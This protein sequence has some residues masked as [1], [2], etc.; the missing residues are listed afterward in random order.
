[1]FHTPR[2]L[3]GERARRLPGLD[4]LRALAIILVLAYHLFPG[5]APGGFLGVDVF[6]VVSGYLITTLL[7]NEHRR[8][9]RIALRRF[10]MRRARR[11]LPALLL[12][13]TV[14]AGLAALIGG[15]VLVGIGWQLAGALTFS[16]NWFS[17]ATGADYL[18]QT[19][20][21]L[22]RHLWSLAVEEQF[23]LLWPVVL[24]ALFAI[25]RPSIRFALV[26]ALAV[27]SAVGMA[28][29]AG[30]PALGTEAA[31][32]AYFSTLTHGFGL[33]AGA[34]LALL[35]AQRTR[36]TDVT[37][38]ARALTDSVGAVAML[39][40]V[41]LSL[42]L[43]IDD[44]TTY[45][46]GLVLAVAL[47]LM[48]ISA[49]DRDGSRLAGVLDA[50]LPR[51]IG[52]RSY[53]LYLWHWP[54]IVLLGARLPDLDRGSLGQTWLL[55]VVALAGSLLLAAASYRLVESPF[56]RASRATSPLRLRAVAAVGAL[57]LLAAASSAVAQAPPR[58]EAA[59]LIA[60]GQL[61]VA[62]SQRRAE[63]PPTRA[64]EPEG[65]PTGLLPT[66]DDITAIGDSVMLAAA[67]QLQ[68][69]FPGMAIDA[70][71]SRQM[72]EAPSIVRALVEAD[73]LRSTV[74]LGLGTNGPIDP[75]TLHEVRALLGPERTLVLVS[76]QAPRGWTEGVNAHLSDF[77]RAYRLVELSDW[78]AAIRPRLSLL[79][80]DQVHP[81]P[82][83]GAVYTE[84]LTA[85]L[86]RI[87]DL[88]PLVDYEANPELL[89][90]R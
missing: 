73:Q 89:R 84:T 11:L 3:E 35:R 83:G 74:V 10:W 79:A 32:A 65:E 6:L 87:A 52:E 75:E 18:T 47:T 66:G 2:P 37:A 61:A 28:L 59:E 5:L 38:R 17:I 62:E 58:S 34:A 29:A 20:P 31:S 7:L 54:V 85:A 27:A 16:Y 71:V 13:V 72:R 4:G 78:Q 63:R 25:P 33:A 44:A 70:V 76:A 90:P 40:L 69:R 81:G 86:Q 36:A 21:E 53:G 14:S 9:G 68:E 15:D 49:A 8:S 82:T 26:G 24:L 50:P 41:G 64:E 88:P 43:A 57:A 55:G 22:L 1:M 67:P 23:Y 45:R 48:V 12:V 42:V 60:A 39:G 56:R 46:G 30:D 19:S 51:W 80:P 77:A